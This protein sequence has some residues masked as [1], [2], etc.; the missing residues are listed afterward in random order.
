MMA[1][2][3]MVVYI[4][5]YRMTQQITYNNKDDNLSFNFIWVEIVGR[6]VPFIVGCRK[7]VSCACTDFLDTLLILLN[8]NVPKVVCSMK[9][10]SFAANV[11]TT[12]MN[13]KILVYFQIL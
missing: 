13:V 2:K 11:C 6:F 8:I 5:Y 10:S 7:K 12:Q 3:N 9:N 1:L 4:I